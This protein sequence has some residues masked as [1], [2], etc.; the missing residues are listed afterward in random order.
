MRSEG[1]GATSDE[2]TDS[3]DVVRAAGAIPWRPREQ[4]IEV[5]VIHRPKY[6]DW[7][8]PKGKLD[9]GETDEDAARREVEEETGLRGRLGPEL[10]EVSYPDRRG[11]PKQVRYFELSEPEGEF[12]ATSEVDEVRWLSP[13][14]ARELLS[15]A[16]DI[17]LLD[18]LLLGRHNGSDGGEPSTWRRTPHEP[19]DWF[20]G[21]ELDRARRY[22]RPLTRLRLARTALTTLAL[23]AV[24]VTDAAPRLVRELGVTGWAAQLAVLVLVLELASLV[25]N[26][27]FD[28]WVDL[29]HDRE[30]GLST[31][32]GR[33]FAA[34]QVKS[35]LLGTVLNVVLLLP[36]YALIRWTDWWWLLGWALVVGFSVLLGL[37][38]PVVIAPIFNKFE[39]LDDED[40]G[41]R[42]SRVADKAGVQITGAF[43]ADESTRSRRDNAYVAGLGATR[44]VVLYDNLLEHPPEVVEQVVAHEIGHWRRRHLRRQIPIV[45]GLALVVFAGLQLLTEWDGM[46]D[47]VDVPSHPGVPRI[48]EPTALPVLLLAVQ[49]GMLLVGVV[50]S[51]VSRAFERQADLDAL[52]LLRQPATMADMHRRLHVKNVSDLDPGPLKRLLGSHPTPAERLAFTADWAAAHGDAL[53]PES[54][55]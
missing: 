14:A 37:I 45:A 50:T 6:D 5:L 16:W 28:A 38:F 26:V 21:E 31:Q 17:E 29:R 7:S 53:A 36:L 34:D 27:G 9:P 32:T 4:G 8:W 42:L 2:V 48:G 19:A 18:R 25:L 49:V 51:W 47:A 10:G 23:L 33:K 15:Y 55:D 41:G 24:L 1:S 13:G 22:Q 39:P 46:F 43:V 12:E 30:W 11:R 52:E 44:R 3:K 20:S 40:L 35:L 54:P